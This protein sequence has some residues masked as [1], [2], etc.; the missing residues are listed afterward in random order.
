MWES[1]QRFPRA[2]GNEGNLLLVFLVSH[3]PS[4]PQ[5]FSCCHLS[6]AVSPLEAGKQ[7]LLRL[8]HCSR[9]GRVT[10]TGRFPVQLLYC[11]LRL[12]VPPQIR[13]LPQNLPCLPAPSSQEHT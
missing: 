4:F 5:P 7:P 12:Q 13:K 11:Q 1:P 3:S 8:L 6:C 2:V 9:R 10:A